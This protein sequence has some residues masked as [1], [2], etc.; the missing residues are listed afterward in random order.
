MGREDE[1]FLPFW[2]HEVCLVC[3]KQEQTAVC[4][5]EKGT[6]VQETYLQ[7]RRNNSILLID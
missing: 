6:V 5:Q 2:N 7:H 4:L 1:E 3:I